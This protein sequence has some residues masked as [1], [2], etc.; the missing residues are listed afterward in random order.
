[1]R[2]LVPAGR[3]LIP[4]VLAQESR[5][6]YYGKNKVIYEKFA[7]KSYATEHFQIFFYAEET[8]RS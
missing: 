8:R 3:F 1:M 6:P 5:F 7:W 4:P 2:R